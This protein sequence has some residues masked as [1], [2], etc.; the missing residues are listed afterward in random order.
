MNLLNY[1]QLFLKTHAESGRYQRT[2]G[3]KSKRGANFLKENHE[4]L[5]AGKFKLQVNK[6]IDQQ[7]KK[8]SESTFLGNRNLRNKKA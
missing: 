3:K 4:K 1:W 5:T 6:T 8:K 2:G 7:S